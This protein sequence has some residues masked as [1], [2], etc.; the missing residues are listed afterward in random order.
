MR[1]TGRVQVRL[2]GVGSAVVRVTLQQSGQSIDA[3][4]NLEPGEAI[5]WLSCQQGAFRQ[6]SHRLLYWW[7]LMLGLLKS[8]CETGIQRRV[9]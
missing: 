4:V 7:T 6:N 9:N 5:A 8:R 2:A 1:T 3:A